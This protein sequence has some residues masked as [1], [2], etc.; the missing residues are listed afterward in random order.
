MLKQIEE[1]NLDISPMHVRTLKIIHLTESCKA[2]DIANVMHR[3]KAQI[4]RLIS[5]LIKD[6][7]VVK[8]DNPNDK[9]SQYL[10]LTEQG[11]DLI[12]TINQI[13][14]RVF[15]KMT[16]NIPKKELQDFL[17]TCELLNSNLTNTP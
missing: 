17:E 9:R 8:V 12:D 1:L 7:W 15:D 16:Q 6:N 2:S 13:E 14:T 3:D 10:S 4:T 5:P 11:E